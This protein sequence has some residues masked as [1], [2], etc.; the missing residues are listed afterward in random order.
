L[1]LLAKRP[2]IGFVPLF[3]ECDRCTACCRWPGQVRLSE[4]EI[5][6]IARFLGIAEAELIQKFT[7]LTADRRGLALEDKA[8]GECIF[9]SGQDCAIQPVK[10]EQCRGFPNLWNFPNFQAICRAKV[11]EM[12]TAEYEQRLAELKQ[13]PK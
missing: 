9:L 12:Q 1:A 3:Y 7:R 10:P 6:R 2:T 5:S 11:I 8:N 4:A 13:T